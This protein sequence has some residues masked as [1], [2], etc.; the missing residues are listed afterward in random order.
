MTKRDAARLDLLLEMLTA[1]FKDADG[2][3]SM[4]IYRGDAR[5][6]VAAIRERKR[7]PKKETEK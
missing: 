5:A 7:R 6:I 1:R 2:T 4:T 3:T